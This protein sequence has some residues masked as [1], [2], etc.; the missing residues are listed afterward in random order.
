MSEVGGVDWACD[1]CV[2]R[3]WLLSRLA[4]HLELV[5]GRTSEVLA[6]CD[7]DLIEAVAA[8]QRDVVRSALAALELGE[9][10]DRSAAA[11]LEL[12]CR[13][14]SAYPA[15]LLDLEGPPAVLHVA[16]GLRRFRA[17]VA[18]DPVA[19]VGARRATPYGLEVARSLARGLASAGVTVLSGMAL[20]VDG[21]AHA[22]ALAV[23][24][25][26]VAVLPAGADRPYPAA[27][28]ALHAQIRATGAAVSELPPRSEVRR[29]TFAARNRIIAAL[30]AM[31]IVVE[32]GE[33]SG[34]LLTAGFARSL[35]RPVGAVPGRVNSPLSTGSNALLASGAHVV[36][37]PQDVLDALFGAGARAA[38]GTRLPTLRPE[39]RRLLGA[40]GEGHD[41]ASALARAGFG[42][43][44]GLAALAALE[45]SGHIRREPGGRFA[46][47]T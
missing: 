38:P 14:H 47:V 10:R 41:T 8:R 37:G 22:G 13:C 27:K 29:W 43:A 36:R 24:G 21:A 32:A 46:I 1:A 2:R 16:G 12:V 15:R 42:S 7:Q 20:G 23:A 44:D 18:E 28:R 5:R 33:R 25:P 39:L 31:T 26:T 3:S 11:G 9:L 35:G 45:L 6:L 4:G 40:I 30:S 19:I 17:L 34:A